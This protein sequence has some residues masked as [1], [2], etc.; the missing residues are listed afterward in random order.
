M[1]L[2]GRFKAELVIYIE[3]VSECLVDARK[4]V[5]SAGQMAW[6]NVAKITVFLPPSNN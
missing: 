1:E 2:F 6:G 3:R 5:L 4:W